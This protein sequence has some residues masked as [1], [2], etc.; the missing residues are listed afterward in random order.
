MELLGC[1]PS[2]RCSFHSHQG[3]E[4]AV[5]LKPTQQTAPA[6][7]VLDLEPSGSSSLIIQSQTAPRLAQLDAPGGI[8]TSTLPLP[9]E[10]PVHEAQAP[11]ATLPREAQWAAQLLTFISSSSNGDLCFTS[12]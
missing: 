8:H 10:I 9:E 11:P 3:P 5:L 2:L 6:S 4:L 12:P 7:Q 1:S